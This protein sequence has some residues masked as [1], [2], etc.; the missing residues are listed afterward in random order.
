MSMLCVLK[1]LRDGL[2]PEDREQNV[3]VEFSSPNVAKPFHMGHLRSTIIGNFVANIHQSLGHKL[4]KINFLGDWGTQFGLLAYGLQ[5]QKQFDLG[6]LY[7]IYVKV[8]QEAEENE[9]VAIEARK[10]FAELEEGNEDLK[11]QWEEIRNGTIENL[12][13]VYSKLGVEFDHY[14]GESMYGK[15]YELNNQV[16]LCFIQTT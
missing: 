8:N 15:N 12:K 6:E 3:I 7:Q 1:W 11:K 4:T 9:N 14:H 13:E 16:L 10:L 2:F 5:G